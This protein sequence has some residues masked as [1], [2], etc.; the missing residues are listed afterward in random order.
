LKAVEIDLAL[1]IAENVEKKSE[2]KGLIMKV[3]RRWNN[4]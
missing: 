2:K 1:E 3:S 4:V